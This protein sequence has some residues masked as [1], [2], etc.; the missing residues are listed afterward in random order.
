MHHN[1][2]YIGLESW[3]C[4]QPVKVSQSRAMAT[5][6]ETARPTPMAPALNAAYARPNIFTPVPGPRAAAAAQSPASV[7]DIRSL[8]MV[9]D[10]EQSEGNL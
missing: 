1:V 4:S 9:V 8:D 7:F 2:S 6:V 3:L 5:I 10:Y